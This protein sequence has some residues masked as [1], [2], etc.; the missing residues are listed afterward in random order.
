MSSYIAGSLIGAAAVLAGVLITAVRDGRIRKA[1]RAERRRAELHQAMYEY[2]AAL[3]GVTYDLTSEPAAPRRTAFDEMM[4][5]AVE[6]AGFELALHLF[7]RLLRRAVYGRRQYEV[8]DR[9]AVASA[10][11]RLI[12]PPEVEEMMRAADTMARLYKAGD[13][14]WSRCWMELRSEMRQRFRDVLLSVETSL[15]TSSSAGR[16]V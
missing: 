10:R 6:K 1:E 15:E 8:V 4:D 7:I 5:R 3:D 14:E 11:L 9:L 16:G 2:L 13:E 12:A